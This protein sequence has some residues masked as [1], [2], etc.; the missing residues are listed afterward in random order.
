VVVR[1]YPDRRVIEVKKDPKSVVIRGIVHDL[2]DQTL[3]DAA[4][5]TPRTPWKVPGV[6]DPERVAA[7]AQGKMKVP[8]ALSESE[9]DRS[10]RNLRRQNPTRHNYKMPAYSAGV[11]SLAVHRTPFP[12]RHSSMPQ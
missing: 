11:L 8:H 1:T 12:A 3:A 4:A 7:K 9:S 10:R 5:I 2:I 6:D